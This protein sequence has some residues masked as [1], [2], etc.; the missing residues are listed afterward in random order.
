MSIRNCS[1]FITPRRAV[2]AILPTAVFIVIL[3]CIPR[4]VAHAASE[5]LTLTNPDK[6]CANCHKE[7]DD[8][9]EHSSMAK[10]SGLAADGLIPGEFTHAASGITYKLFLRDGQALGCNMTVRRQR[11]PR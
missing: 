3:S 10:G 2:A 1:R 5:T 11:P 8:R 7:I 4:Q 6:A 9:Y